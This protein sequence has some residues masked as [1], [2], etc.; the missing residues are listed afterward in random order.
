MDSPAAA[1]GLPLAEAILDS[2]PA[3]AVLVDRLRSEAGS[4]L[5]ADLPTLS[6]LISPRDA[7]GDPKT[8]LDRIGKTDVLVRGDAKLLINLREAGLPADRGLYCPPVADPTLLEVPLDARREG[9]A[10]VGDV[11]AADPA[12]FGI[13]LPSLQALWKTLCEE[14]ASRWIPYS[15]DQFPTFCRRAQRRVDVQ[16]EDGSPAAEKFSRMLRRIAADNQLLIGAA[17]DLA[18]RNVPLRLYG[19]GWSLIES[20]A[21]HVRGPADENGR[22]DAITQS[23]VLLHLSTSTNATDLVADAAAAGCAVIVKPLPSDPSDHG[24]SSMLHIG[25]ACQSIQ[26]IPGLLRTIERLTSDP[27]ARL[28][29]TTAARAAIAHHGLIPHRLATLRRFLAQ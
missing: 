29:Q 14:I 26:D 10:I 1:S 11:A 12:A 6:W 13:M 20:L 15:D 28:K 16:L 7:E 18:K 4:L 21:P 19:A 3:A 22:L 24:V 5:P 23:A 8:I 27:V 25:S 9:V 2:D 17:T